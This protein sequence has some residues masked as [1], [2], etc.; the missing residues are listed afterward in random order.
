[1]ANELGVQYD[2]TGRNVY[3]LLRNSVNAIWNGSAFVA[4]A[5]LDLGSYDI[6]A[7]EQGT[8][9]R[10]YVA[11]MPAVAAGVYHQYAYEQVG[12]S[13]A[14]TDLLIGAGPIEW[15]G[16]AELPLSSVPLTANK[17]GYALSNAGID[18]L[19]TRALTE[20]YNAD[21]AAPTVAQALFVIMQR[22]TEF[23]IAS[24]TITVNRLDGTTAA[25]TLTLDSATT[26]TSSTRA[27]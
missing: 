5:T 4:Y 1:M 27:T 23:S 10:F 26:P 13:P 21:G 25:F 17:T 11:N 20:S 2:V 7:T 6:P 22:V 3:F 15:D 16:T 24:T 9:S 19:F 12:A 14:E 8:A 18:A